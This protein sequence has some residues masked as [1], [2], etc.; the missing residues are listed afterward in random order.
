MAHVGAEHQ[1]RY[2]LSMGGYIGL[3]VAKR[4]GE[5]GGV[6]KL[7][8]LLATTRQELEAGKLTEALVADRLLEARRTFTGFANPVEQELAAADVV[9]DR[10]SA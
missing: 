10:L 7:L 9:A 5:R 8:N 4:I 2:V 1:Q 6:E 3:M